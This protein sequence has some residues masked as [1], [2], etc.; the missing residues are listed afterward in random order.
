MVIVALCLVVSVLLYVRTRLV[1]R[2]RR[3]REALAANGGG[4]EQEQ[5][6]AEP[7][8]FPLGGDLARNDWEPGMI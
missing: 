3:E 1:E 5:P 6:R 2:M 4:Q 8:V 7:P